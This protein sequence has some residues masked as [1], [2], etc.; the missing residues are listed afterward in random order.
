MDLNEVP[1]DQTGLTETKIEEKIKGLSKNKGALEGRDK[2]IKEVEVSKQKCK[3]LELRMAEL[4][5]ILKEDR[6]MNGASNGAT[7]IEA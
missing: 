5:G 6:S 4:K 3:E 7:L 2:V 1:N